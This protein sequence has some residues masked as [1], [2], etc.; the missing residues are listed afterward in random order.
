MI[1]ELSSGSRSTARRRWSSWF[2]MTLAAVV[3]TVAGADANAAESLA[4]AKSLKIGIIGT[5]RIGSSLARYWA[6]AGHEVYISSRHP[7]ELRALAAELGPKAHAGTPREAAAFGSVI[8]VSVPYSAIAQL[9]TDLSSELAGKVIIDT[10]NPIE[11]RDGPTAV[12]YQAMGAG[13]STAKL[14]HSTRVVRAFNCIPAATLAGEANRQPER[15]AIPLGG[16]DAQALAVTQRLVNDAGFDAVV[17]G[18][19]TRSREFDLGQPLAK[20]TWTAAE[21]RAALAKP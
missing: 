5:G 3:A 4:L 2:G 1:E 7:E 15:Y 21:L 19:L 10:S 14:L 20:G 18:S 12:E 6:K 16:D 11:R 13:L 8:L 17:V 9:G